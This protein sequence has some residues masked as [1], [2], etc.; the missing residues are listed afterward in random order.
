L[1]NA[2]LSGEIL[3]N[4]VN[5]ILDA[6]KLKSDKI[7]IYES[8]TSFIDLVKKALTVNSE[9]LREKT[10]IA[11]AHIDEKIPQSILIDA[12]RLLQVLL[13]LMSNA[14]KFTPKGGKI[15][16]YAQWCS[17]QENKENL[18]KPIAQLINKPMR[19]RQAE[20]S[21]LNLTYFQEMTSQSLILFHNKLEHV[22][23]HTLQKGPESWCLA[24]KD[25]WELNIVKM[26]INNEPSRRNTRDGY[27]GHLKIQIMDTGSG[28]AENEIPK[29][30][31][32]FE[33]A[34]EHS[35]NA[36]GGSGLGLWICKQIC[37]RMNGEIVLYSELGKG[38][39]FVFYIPI[40]SNDHHQSVRL[41]TRMDLLGKNKLKALIVDD[42]SMN[43][44]VHQLLLEQQG[45]QVVTA[46][47]GNEAVEKYKTPGNVFNLILMDVNMPVMDGFTAAKKIREWEIEN[48][49]RQTDIYFVTGEYFNEADVFLRFKNV[50]GSSSGIKYLN[51]PLSSDVLRKIIVQY[52]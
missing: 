15:E 17:A 23:D 22:P 13:N 14:V 16:I 45:V 42:F 4:L 24:E 27:I 34:I 2:Q 18:L 12:S 44:Y 40:H 20:E 51:K 37:H 50:G 3:L 30:F 21:Q 26:P 47:D 38:T 8:E 9:L 52:K 10:M 46:S 19:G 28:I 36:H 39:S 49:K 29:L 48:N 32:M 25:L 11:K 6:A 35:R 43:R 41:S 1:K 7:D 5:N 31:G 33:Q